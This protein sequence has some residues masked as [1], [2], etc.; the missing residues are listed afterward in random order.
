M[1]K[2]GRWKW[3]VILICFFLA[4][5]TSVMA[6]TAGT[7]ALEGTVKDPSGAVIPNA[8]VTA[9]SLDNGQVRTAT[10][11]GDGT[12]RFTL[13]PPGNY[14][15]RIE[16]AGFKPVEIPSAIVSVTET[17]VLDRNLEVGTQTQTVTVEAG[18]EA[19]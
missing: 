7:G 3:G 12:Y 16:A 4:G 14:R 18:V 13:L 5:A 17:A 19:I 2:G 15:V 10:T 1:F 11:S 6:Q 9:T 8:T